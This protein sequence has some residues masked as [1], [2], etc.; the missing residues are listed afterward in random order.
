MYTSHASEVSSDEERL[1]KRRKMSPFKP[2]PGGR[3]KPSDRNGPA[4]SGFAAKMMAKMGYVEG[5][6]LGAEGKGRL[7]P[8]ETQLRPQGAG[9]GAVKEKTKQAREEERREAAFRGEVLEDSSEEERK[10]RKKSKAQNAPG[11]RSSDGRTPLTK[12][13][14]K[15]K[16][17]AEIETAAEGLKVPDALKGIIDATG[18]ETR[19]LNSTVGLMS[20]TTYV[21]SETESVKIAKRA[22]RDL[23]SF[24]DEWV[25]LKQREEYYIADNIQLLEGI[26]ADE[27][28]FSTERDMLDLIRGL[29]AMPTVDASEATPTPMWTRLVSKLKSLEALPTSKE[30][31]T[32]RQEL[33]VAAL[34]PL[35]K[36]TMSIWNPLEDPAGVA[37][38]LKE[39][40]YILGVQ[41]ASS[42]TTL[43]KHSEIG[44]SGLHR[45]STSPYESM[46][47]T[48]WIPVVRTA[49]MRDW[50]V[51][52]SAAM[53]AVV[54]AWMPVLPPFILGHVIDRLVVQRLTDSV[55]VWN[56]TKARKKGGHS[57]APHVWLFPWLQY[58]DDQHTDPKNPTGLMSEV[59]R[60]FKNILSSWNLAQGLIP[61]LEHWEAVLGSDLSSI[62]IRYLLPR[63]R[64]HLAGF[65][66]NPR[67]QDMAL[68]EDLLQW[69][70]YFSAAVMAE[71]FKT[72][73]FPKWRDALYIWLTSSSVNYDEVG[74]WYQWWKSV[75]DDAVSP[76]FNSKPPMSTEW[77][78]GLELMLQASEVGPVATAQFPH[79]NAV[80][81]DTS[82]RRSQSKERGSSDTK[83]AS[84]GLKTPDPNGAT[85]SFKD[86]VEEWCQENDVFLKPLREADVQTGLPLFRITASATGRGGVV[87]YLKGDV[88]W[89]RKSTS[90]AGQTTFTPMGLDDS[91]GKLAEG[92]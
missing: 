12:A 86:V 19:I 42:D 87:V 16:T 63:F 49:I 66:V 74:Q 58:L 38:F 17:V 14:P 51:K 9:L 44:V 37:P 3:P 46:L 84:V 5:Q 61:G 24:T 28:A 64:P 34:H 36:T 15:F 53:I 25:A 79:P 92:R 85:A 40:H 82:S 22:Q 70:P 4:P 45:R 54:E 2:S 1:P 59:K 62:F 32:D 72:D 83:E 71:F 52:D 41:A 90:V 33:A 20:Q 68:L 76:D 88:V 55:A 80:A 35:F 7:A 26:T 11:L 89:V 57:L 29:Q 81:E 6:G 65:E 27:E 73:F 48:Y 77:Q 50:D 23:M 18:S 39:V 78:T 75:F 10:R 43:V 31:N 56:P 13:K 21:P 91:L 8:I 60:K 30:T 69:S 47:Q 67:D